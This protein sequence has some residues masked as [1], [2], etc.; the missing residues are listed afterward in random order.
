MSFETK[1][2]PDL[3]QA[4]PFFAVPDIEASVRSATASA[5][6]CPGSGLTRRS[7]RPRSAGCWLQRGA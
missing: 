5:S 6:R 7:I 2:A 3:R 1:T 4:V